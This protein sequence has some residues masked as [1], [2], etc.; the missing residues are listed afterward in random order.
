MRFDPDDA[1]ATIDDLL[2]SKRYEWARTTLEGIRQTIEASGIC[3]LRQREAIEH[4]ILG[5]LKH[6][7]G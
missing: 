7:V 2:A 6:D 3:T 5:R 1:V 4:I